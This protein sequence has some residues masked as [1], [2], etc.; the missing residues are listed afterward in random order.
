MRKRWRKIFKKIEKRLD[1]KTNNL[2]KVS[3][4]GTN[5]CEPSKVSNS[6]TNVVN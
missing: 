4:S 5:S 2:S 3:N 1:E 6:G